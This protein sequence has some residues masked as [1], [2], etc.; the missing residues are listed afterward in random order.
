MRILAISGSLRAA[1]TN[2]AVLR[3]AAR[4][5]PQGVDV[6]P[7]DGLAALPFFDPDL[8]G[9]APPGPVLDLRAEV[10]RSDALL[11]CS[12]EYARGV[13]GALKNALDWLVSSADFPGKP[14]AV[15][16][17]SQ[18]ATHADASLRL[19]LDT[20]SARLVASASITLPLLGRGLDAD[21]IAVD[22][23]LSD[24]L[25][26]ALMS[27]VRRGRGQRPT[28][29]ATVSL[30]AT[31]D[32]GKPAGRRAGAH[33]MIRHLVP[34]GVIATALGLASGA[35]ADDA[36][37]PTFVALPPPSA[38]LPAG[39]ASAAVTAPL[40]G[41]E[42]IYHGLYVGTEV[43]G[44]GGHGVK[45]GFGGDVYG[46]YERLMENG[47]LLGVQGATGYTPSILGRPGLRGFDFGEASAQ[48]AYP[49]GRLTPFLTAGLIVA[50]PVTGNSLAGTGHDGINELMNGSGALYA[51][52]RVGAGVAYALTP[53]TSVSLGVS[54]GRGLAEGA[55]FP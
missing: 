31:G 25:R 34:L 17:A 9:E 49:M 6:I 30:R 33:R 20:M 28:R 10:C 37:L 27:P 8:D 47:V 42:S 46:G 43:F 7:Y 48:V 26:A 45:G 12:P 1:S 5:A 24:Q 15:I 39:S 50:P 4:L 3:A 51:A 29:P 55:G 41:P 23:V 52:P 11:I 19:I 13:A 38:L 54:V 32:A 40:A 35:A 2:T 53:N 21:G 18:R 14:A 36:P 44:I 16:N 22:P